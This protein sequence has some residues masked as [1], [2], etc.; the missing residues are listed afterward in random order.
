MSF[1]ELF[2][3]MNTFSGKINRFVFFINDEVAGLFLFDTENHIH[4]GLFLKIGT[5]L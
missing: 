1:E 2:N 4:L 5:S 3:F